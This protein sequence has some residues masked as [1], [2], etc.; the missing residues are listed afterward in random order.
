MLNTRAWHQAGAH[1]NLQTSNKAQVMVSVITLVR[2]LARTESGVHLS[3]RLDCAPQQC[4]KS[5]FQLA[6][7]LRIQQQ[8]KN[9]L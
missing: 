1:P 8:V 7:Q 5:L 3:A 2:G 6:Y 9:I 4:K